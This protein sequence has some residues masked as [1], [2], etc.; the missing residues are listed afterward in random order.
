MSSPPRNS[1]T[2]DE[3]GVSFSDFNRCGGAIGI[4][5]I[6]CSLCDSDGVPFEGGS[7]VLGDEYLRTVS[8]VVGRVEID[9]VTEFGERFR[10]STPTAREPIVCVTPWPE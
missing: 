9:A 6:L 5:W 1:Q 7:N 10:Q 8:V 2:Q 4:Q 3:I